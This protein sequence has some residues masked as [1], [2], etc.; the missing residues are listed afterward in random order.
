MG[1]PAADPLPDP[2][3]LETTDVEASKERSGSSGC[4]TTSGA[5]GRPGE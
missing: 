2:E 1:G 4:R 5:C 3:G